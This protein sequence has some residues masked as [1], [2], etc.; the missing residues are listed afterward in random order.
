MP[1]FKKALISMILTYIVD[2][3]SICPELK[4]HV[5]TNVQSM[6][7]EIAHSH[8]TPTWYELILGT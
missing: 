2:S 8:L 4:V 7:P 1:I 5:W 3:F 6:Q